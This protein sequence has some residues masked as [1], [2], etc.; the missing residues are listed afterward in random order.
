ML[1][2]T[3]EVRGSTIDVVVNGVEWAGGSIRIHRPDVPEGHLEDV[4]QIRR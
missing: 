2:P 4:L 1:R 3:Q